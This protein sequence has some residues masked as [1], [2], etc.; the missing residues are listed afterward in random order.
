MAGKANVKVNVAALVSGEGTLTK[1]EGDA[2]AAQYRTADR[3][4]ALASLHKGRISYVVKARGVADADGKVVSLADLA[5]VWGVS[6]ASITQG[7]T[8]YA[9]LVYLGLAGESDAVQREAYSAATALRKV[10]PGRDEQAVKAYDSDKEAALADVKALP[11][12]ERVE[13]LRATVDTLKTSAQEHR[14]AAAPSATSAQTTPE[15]SGEA[16]F[17]GKAAVLSA[18]GAIVNTVA[19]NGVALTTGE[20]EQVAR[21]LASIARDLGVDLAEVAALATV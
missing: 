9:T 13:A 15:T 14:K 8:Q 2:L 16:A 20:S 21:Y 11:V 10:S 3:A 1:A 4:E 6:A 19:T 7:H 5:K 12:S 18:L 17:E